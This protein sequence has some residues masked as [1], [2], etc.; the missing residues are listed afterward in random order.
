[1]VLKTTEVQALGGSTPSLP[2]LLTS[3]G[4]SSKGRIPDF[5][6]GDEG[7]S[8]SLPASHRGAIGRRTRLKIV[9]AVGSTPTG[10]T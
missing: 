8:P 5:E 10:G 6:S 4:R 3:F 1:V 7:S 2:A 9:L